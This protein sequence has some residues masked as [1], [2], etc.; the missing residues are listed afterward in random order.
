MLAPPPAAQ[1]LR[2]VFAETLLGGPTP[3]ARPDAERPARA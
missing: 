3:P 1:Q 2:P